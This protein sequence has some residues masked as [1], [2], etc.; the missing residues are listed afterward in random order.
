MGTKDQ[1]DPLDTHTRVIEELRK[2]SVD[3]DR[4]QTL[5][6]TVR[7]LD[8]LEARRAFSNAACRLQEAGYWYGLGLKYAEKAGKL[9]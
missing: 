4:M 6:E 3:I 2:L 1:S 5:V 8:A 7:G 9:A